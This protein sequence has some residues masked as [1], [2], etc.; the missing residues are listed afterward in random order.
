M[1][2]RSLARL[3]NPAHAFDFPTVRAYN[4]AAA[5]LG[6]CLARIS[7]EWGYGQLQETPPLTRRGLE[8]FL[9][10]AAVQRRIR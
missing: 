10:S 7:R 1:L 8:H 3:R 5:D 6:G 9:L 2:E 4:L